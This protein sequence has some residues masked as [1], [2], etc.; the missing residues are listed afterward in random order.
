MVVYDRL[1]SNEIMA[2]IP[3]HVERIYAGKA[4]GGHAM[5]QE[6]I[7][8]T[9][10][11]HAKLGKKV[12]R[13]KGGDPFIFGRGGEEADYLESHHISYEIVPG[14][15]SA[16]AISAALNIPL[17]HRGLATSV[18]FITGHQQKDRPLDLNWA[19][20]C[21]PKTTLVIY[22]GLTNISEIST[23]LI[24]AGLNKNT[25]AAVIENGTTPKQ[26]NGFATLENLN[27]VISEQN[28]Q[29]PSLIIIGKV[30]ALAK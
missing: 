24:K 21:D 8:E 29:P 7:N 26:R 20:L 4:P 14:I 5:S 19:S 28:F 27:R 16:S 11:R 6:E 9:L 10:A 1:I 22:M 17:T 18:R 25:P 2:L 3:A 30:V 13:L 12:V 15:T 23:Q